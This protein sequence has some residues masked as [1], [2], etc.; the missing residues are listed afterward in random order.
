MEVGLTKQFD[1]LTEYADISEPRWM[2]LLLNT[3]QRRDDELSAAYFVW[4]VCRSSV[5]SH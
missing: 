2:R 3:H 5:T 1:L 4:S